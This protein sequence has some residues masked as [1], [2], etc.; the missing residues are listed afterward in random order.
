MNIEFSKSAKKLSL[1]VSGLV[2][3]AVGLLLYFLVFSGSSP[4]TPA[5]RL[6]S[7]LTDQGATMYG[8]PS[9]PHCQDQKDMFGDAFKYV[10]YVDCSEHREKCINDGV[11]TVPTWK[12]SDETV[13]GT[14]EL[15]ELANRADCE[16]P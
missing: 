14:Q 16:Y 1:V 10:D 4:D 9:C 7:C 13:V 3:I 11:R 8:L 15:E 5:E 6:A 2:L 12:I